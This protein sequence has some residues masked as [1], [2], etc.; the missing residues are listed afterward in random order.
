M[1]TGGLRG[2]PYV[3]EAGEMDVVAV[4]EPERDGKR[5]SLRRPCPHAIGRD[6]VPGCARGQ[7][8]LGPRSVILDLHVRVADVFLNRQIP[9][10]RIGLAGRPYPLD[11]KE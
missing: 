8:L 5:T 6:V 2:P 11:L 9:H 7:D 4:F 10:F 1:E 3:S